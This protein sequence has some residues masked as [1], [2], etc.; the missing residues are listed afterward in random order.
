VERPETLPAG[1]Y[2]LFIHPRTGT[3]TSTQTTMGARVDST[4]ETFLK[5]WLLRGPAFSLEPL[6]MYLE[7]VRAFCAKLVR[8]SAQGYT[9]TG[10]WDHKSDSF[11][12]EMDAVACFA[13]A[14]LALGGT[15]LGDSLQ[16]A[17]AEELADTCHAMGKAT[18][19]GLAPEISALGGS[20]RVRPK[21]DAAHHL[22]RPEV[23]E[24]F[25]VLHR[26]TKR[27]R[28]RQWGWAV[29]R[30][31][32]THAR[33]PRGGYSGLKDV[34]GDGGKAVREMRAGAD[35]ATAAGAQGV[36]AV[37][38]QGVPPRRLWQR[39]ELQW[40]VSV[41]HDDR[42]ESFFLSETLKYLLLL[43]SDDDVLPLGEWVLNTEAHPLR[44][45]RL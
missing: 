45:P 37:A 3:Y 35:A 42:M 32:E 7:S 14:M 43:F 39:R 28:Y 21:E 11:K 38:G 26:V 27:P 33:L 2:P 25:F 5:Q 10:V 23:L 13:P 16:L 20:G 4:Y 22:L 24:T 30:A 41:A 6:R 40:E 8:T 15:A 19:T 31:L 1:L 44:V 17:L 12:D 9:Y 34:D 29:F 18:L 36:E